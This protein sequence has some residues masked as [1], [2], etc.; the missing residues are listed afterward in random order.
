MSIT[1]KAFRFALTAAALCG[2]AATANA[3]PKR[4]VILDFDGP[5]QLADAG[6]SSVL[7]ILGEEYEVVPTKRWE[8]A[9]SAAAKR[10]HGPEQWARAAKE[11]GIGA[12]VEGVIQEEGRRKI[13]TIT[14]READNGKE[15][16]PIDVR[17]DAKAGISAEN[18]RQLQ[19]NLD[20][21][22]YWIDTGH[23]ET[24]AVYAPVSSTGIGSSRSSA[25]DTAE[26]TIRPNPSNHHRVVVDDDAQGE[27]VAP[28]KH[29]RRAR[30]E[31]VEQGDDSTTAPAHEAKPPV[32]ATAT[33]PDEPV[34]D[35]SVLFPANAKEQVQLN[36]LVNHVPQPTPRFMIDTGLY[37]GS[38]N[39]TFEG[40]A[41][42]N[43]QQFNGVSSKGFQVN[44][45]AYPFPLKKIDGV[46][47]G[48]GFTGSMHHSVASSVDFDDTDEVD[49]YVINQNGWELGVHYR[50]PINDM[51]TID[52]GAFYG[53]QTYQILDA[54]QDFEIPDTK[55][56][57]LGASAHLDLNITDRATI[58]FGA[59]Y[60]TVLDTGDLSSTDWFGPTDASGI[61][62]EATFTIPLPSS[63]YIRGQ[64]S[65]QHISLEMSGGGIIT[66]QENVTDGSD[67]MI[68]GN[69]NLGIAF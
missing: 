24:P 47:S 65:Y 40:D 1:T 66:D 69:V 19:T 59:R 32:T 13:L 30:T 51:V 64:L 31:E 17:M 9:K 56:S 34:H 28:P 68:M 27:E 4:V 36:P 20:Q 18:T 11:S 3:K 67:S 46:M 44:V 12:I 22:L 54:S 60:F 35:I 63:L 8:A 21:L 52:G 6:R 50:T 25:D 61:G 57:Y 38:R 43:L 39:L 41:D 7:S 26:V 53:N 45:A 16:D 42:S 2:A 55:Y 58:G 37:M 5:R 33:D 29:V 10:S 23:N 15:F 14:V 48:V 62:L 49:N